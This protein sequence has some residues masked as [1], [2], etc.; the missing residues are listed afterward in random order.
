MSTPIADAVVPRIQAY[1]AEQT[2]AKKIDKSQ[3]DWRTHLPIFPGLAFEPG[4]NY[5]W[6]LDTS[7]GTL[8]IRFRPDAAP[9]HVA[10]FIYL[11]E[12]GFFDGLTFHRVIRGFMAQGGC[13]LGTG[14]GSPGY[15]FSG[16]YR[17][18]VVH[19]TPG[20][21]SMANTGMPRSDGSQFFITFG[22]TPHLDMRHT[23]FGKVVDG[24]PVLKEIEKKGSADGSGRTSEP[25]VIRKA[26]IAVSPG[27]AG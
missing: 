7:L 24:M 1:I 2:E 9:R 11:T 17:R 16:E 22:P 10:N 26:T 5:D 13:P 6:V 23:V 14:T 19:D 12:L 25:I 18:D 27:A 21:L 15:A 8:T 4:L 3:S 20:I